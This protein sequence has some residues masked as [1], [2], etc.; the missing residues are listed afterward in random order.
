MLKKYEILDEVE[1]GIT[2]YKPKD[3]KVKM[4][5]HGEGGCTRGETT[6]ELDKLRE[7]IGDKND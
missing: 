2:I 1:E 7:L 3:N 4:I 6:F 5:W